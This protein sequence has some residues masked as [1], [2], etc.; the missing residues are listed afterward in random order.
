M[1]STL[2]INDDWLFW[3]SLLSIIFNFSFYYFLNDN[4]D[5]DEAQATEND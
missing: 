1:S 3:P 2:E 4:A 5:I